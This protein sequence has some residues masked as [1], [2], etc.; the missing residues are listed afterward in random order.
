MKAVF[1]Q[2]SQN[3]AFTLTKYKELLQLAIDRFEFVDL[4]CQNIPQQAALWRHD[5]DF[6]PCL[7]LQMARVDHEIG[8]SSTFY[9]QVCSEYYN[10]LNFSTIEQ[11][12]EIASMGHRIGLHFSPD[13]NLSGTLESLEHQLMDQAI[14]LENAIKYTVSSFSIHNP[15]TLQ[16]DLF[17][18]TTHSGLR[19]AS[20]SSLRKTYSYCSDSNGYW[21]HQSLESLIVNPDVSRLYALIHPIWWQDKNLLPRDRVNAYFKSI[22]KQF[23]ESYDELLAN[24]NRL[25]LGGSQK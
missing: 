23:Q 14:V 5:V 11:I 8:I 1:N 10:V 20:S 17:D 18:K 22:S 21:R 3:M 9:F 2:Q 25:N 16:S 19:N 7:A 13:P 15:T 12:K 6:S 24:N 4:E